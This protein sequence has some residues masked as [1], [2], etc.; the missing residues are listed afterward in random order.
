MEERHI[1]DV[2]VQLGARIERVTMQANDVLLPNLD[3]HAHDDNHEDDGDGSGLAVLVRIA[4]HVEIVAHV[5]DLGRVVLN[6]RA[7]KYLK[8]SLG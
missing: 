3:S 2:L 6:G 8:Y 4:L 1:G 7:A 5:F